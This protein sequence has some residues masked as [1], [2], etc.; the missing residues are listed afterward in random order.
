MS[1]MVEG[2]T[3]VDK[4]RRDVKDASLSYLSKIVTDQQIN[5]IPP[6]ILLKVVSDLWIPMV[7]S[8]VECVSEDEKDN[9][10][11]TEISLYDKDA[12]LLLTAVHSISTMIAGQIRRL[13]ISPAFDKFWFRL[14]HLFGYLL[15]NKSVDDLI[16]ID[17][18]HLQQQFKQEFSNL[19]VITVATGIFAQKKVLWELTEDYV[20]K[21]SYC[22]EVLEQLF[23]GSV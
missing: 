12:E 10:E 3:N 22:P 14:L 16:V 17:D 4:S 7:S 20:A 1:A 2:V 18:N 5:S 19:V 8:I 15:G 23:G 6:T 11:G 21:Y 13:V 9:A